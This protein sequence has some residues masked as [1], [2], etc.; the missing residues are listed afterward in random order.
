MLCERD[1]HWRRTEEVRDA[2]PLHGGEH[3]V[4]VEAG[5]HDDGVAALQLPERDHGHAEDVEH[6]TCT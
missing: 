2:V 3:G 4:H 1:H 5:H 6:F